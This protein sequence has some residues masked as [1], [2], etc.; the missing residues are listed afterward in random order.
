MLLPKVIENALKEQL[1]RGSQF[2]AGFKNELVK[3]QRSEISKARYFK[4][5]EAFRK[6]SEG[7]WGG[8]VNLQSYVLFLGK[9]L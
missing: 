8:Y 6:S 2:I 4:A 5:E 9:L 1:H 7:K 3:E